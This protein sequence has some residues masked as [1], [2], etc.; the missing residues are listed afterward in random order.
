MECAARTK[1]LISE[2][3]KD[4]AV[5]RVGPALGDNVED[6]QQAARRMALTDLALTTHD[7]LKST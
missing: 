4:G 5:K 3:A 7:R 6:S 2:A 1:R